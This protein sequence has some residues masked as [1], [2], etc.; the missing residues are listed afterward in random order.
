MCAL[1]LAGVS[2]DYCDEMNRRWNPRQAESVIP[3][4]TWEGFVDRPRELKP[5]V[6]L[7]VRRLQLQVKLNK[8]YTSERRKIECASK[9]VVETKFRV[10]RMSG[11]DF[12]RSIFYLEMFVS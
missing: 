3:Y 11:S 5:S 1:M 7:S 4:F 9:R 12:G 2:L 8:L 10:G 6:L